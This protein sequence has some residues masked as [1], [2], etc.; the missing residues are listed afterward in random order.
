MSVVTSWSSSDWTEADDAVDKVELE[1]EDV[2]SLPGELELDTGLSSRAGELS[3][4]DKEYWSPIGQKTENN[5][6]IGQK[7]E[8][9]SLIGQKTE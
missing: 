1:A 4:D 9:N 8:N 2:E 5:S 6:L 7:T 3:W